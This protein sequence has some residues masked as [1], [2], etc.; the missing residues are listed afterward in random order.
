MRGLGGIGAGELF[1][2]TFGPDSC[3]GFSGLV[4]GLDEVPGEKHDEK[5]E[6]Y[7]QADNDFSPGEGFPVGLE[8]VDEARDGNAESAKH[9]EEEQG[10]PED[11]IDDFL[12]RVGGDEPR[13]VA[14]H[15]PRDCGYPERGEDTNDMDQSRGVA[16]GLGGF[17]AIG[18]EGHACS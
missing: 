17:G 1:E 6:A 3:A 5:C 13:G 16:L 7:C 2:F 10:F 11:A 18:L 14:V 4:E 9:Y 12:P 8:V 15:E